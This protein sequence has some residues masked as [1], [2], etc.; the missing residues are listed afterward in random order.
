MTMI[1]LVLILLIGGVIAALSERLSSN[2]PRWVA[3]TTIALTLGYLLAQM[4]T[5]DD[6][7]RLQASTP[8]DPTTWLMHFK[9]PWIPAFGIN[10]E[11]ALDGISLLMVLLTLFLGAVAVSASWTDVD[12]HQGFFEANLLWTLAGVLGVFYVSFAGSSDGA[13]SLSTSDAAARFFPRPEVSGVVDVPSHNKLVECFRKKS[14][15][16]MSV[17]P[18]CSA[19]WEGLRT[20]SKSPHF[21]ALAC[22]T[23]SLISIGWLD[24][25]KDLS[26]VIMG[27]SRRPADAAAAA[28]A[29]ARRAFPPCPLISEVSNRA[30][31]SL[32]NRRQSVEAKFLG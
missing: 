13:S 12:Q 25:P 15:M 22:V 31:L 29:D 26:S 11:M 27:C 4:A 7:Q 18:L 14:T 30:S 28:P 23:S 8:S 20:L 6:L 3:L 24:V 16:M 9:S 32:S 5:M 1:S 10:L 2:A 17:A 19:S 21:S